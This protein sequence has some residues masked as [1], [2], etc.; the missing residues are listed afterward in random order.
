[1]KMRGSSYSFIVIMVIML[2]VIGLSLGFEY[3]ESKLL[4]IVIS[5]GVFILSAIGLWREI[6]AGGERKGTVT[7]GEKTE[8]EEARKD[9]HGYLLVGAWLVG[10][11]LA[12][13]LLGFIIAIPLLIL[14]Y[15][16][17]HGG[18]WFAAVAFAILTT[19]LVWVIFEFILHI[20][21][22][23]GLLLTSLGY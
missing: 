12:I 10:F 19:V 4:P 15:M 22:Y 2:V 21:L 3:I 8:R 17:S 11:S 13:Y 20:A 23:R 9:W 14:A 16:K 1:M 7:E 6:S 18:R 5:S